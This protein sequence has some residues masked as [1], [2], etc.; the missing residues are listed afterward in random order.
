MIYKRFFTNN[1]TEIFIKASIV[2][3]AVLTA[4]GSSYAQ[5]K[6]SAVKK[7]KLLSVLRS[8]QLQTREIVAIVKS[9]GVD[10]ELSSDIQ[11]ELVSAGARPEVIEAVRRFDVA[12]DDSEFVR[13]ANAVKHL[14]ENRNRFFGGQCAAFL[15][16]SIERFTAHK[17]QNHIKLFALPEQ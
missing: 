2:C 7:E 9:N 14:A 17:F 4:Y 15:Q 6:G 5:Y 1:K 16:N 11:A 13:V 8:K 12:V 10:F 3:L